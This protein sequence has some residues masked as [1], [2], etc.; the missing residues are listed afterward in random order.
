M[1]HYSYSKIPAFRQV[2]REVKESIQGRYNEETKT[3]SKDESIP[4]PTITFTGT[5]KAHGTN[6]G[7]VVSDTEYY[8]LSR[9]SVITV[10][11]DNY[12]FAAFAEQNEVKHFCE[13]I[14]RIL[15]LSGQKI[16]IYGEW[17]GKGIQKNV[18]ISGLSRMWIIFAVKVVLEDSTR[19]ADISD[20]TVDLAVLPIYTVNNF[21]TYSFD[22]DFNE[23]EFS[24]NSITEVVE[25]IEKSCPIGAHFNVAGI[26][27]GLVLAGTL[28]D[29]TSLRFKVKGQKHS[30]TKVKTLAPVDTERLNSIKDFVEYSVTTSRLEQG[31]QATLLV[32]ETVEFDRKNLGKFIKWVSS[33]IL[34]EEKDTLEKNG[35]AMKDVGGA[36]SKA[37]KAYFFKMETE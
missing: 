2:V 27:E 15:G 6:S 24:V 25:Q 1:E 7:I 37:A 28:P 36:L 5:V 33:D 17:C 8:A 12:G 21:P 35:L 32:S 19:W 20:L 22:I 13:A 11:N 4:L 31:A 29:G 34:A 10:G 30:A 14:R 23:P 26:G 9:N 3:W 18:A 16:V